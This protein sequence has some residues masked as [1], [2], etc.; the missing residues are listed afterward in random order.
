MLSVAIVMWVETEAVL[1]SIGAIK[2]V[3]QTRKIRSVVKE[4][5]AL[6]AVTV[7]ISMVVIST[8]AELRTLLAFVV[9]YLRPLM[10]LSPSSGK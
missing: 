8:T 5:R 10:N 3:V 7:F 9:V 4:A 6:V 2:V 1:V